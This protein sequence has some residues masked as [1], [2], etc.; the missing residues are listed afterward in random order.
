MIGIVLV[1]HGNIGQEML[2]ATQRIIPDAKHL[3]SVSVES[4]DPPEF[5]RETS[6]KAVMSVDNGLV[7]FVSCLS[8]K[9]FGLC[10]KVSGFASKDDHLTNLEPPIILFNTSSRCPFV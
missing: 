1:S 8:L 2:N 7:H 4:N 9:N 5:I 6:L 10:I 3:C